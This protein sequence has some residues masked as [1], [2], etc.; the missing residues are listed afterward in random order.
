[1]IGRNVAGLVGLLALTGCQTNDDFSNYLARKETVSLSAGN[2]KDANAAQHVI[3]P[4]PQYVGNTR[5]EG[6]GAN[7]V[8]AIEC[9]EGR[10]AASGGASNSGGGTQINIGAGAGGGGSTGCARP[11]MRPTLILPN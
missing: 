1:M 3:D 6:N 5:I 8:K 2:A 7:S 9:Y 4:W 10:S 11:P